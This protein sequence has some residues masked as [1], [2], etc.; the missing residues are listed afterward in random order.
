MQKDGCCADRNQAQHDQGIL[1][2]LDVV[3]GIANLKGTQ[4]AQ[5]G[6][7]AEKAA[8]GGRGRRGFAVSIGHP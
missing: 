2:K 1:G 3:C 7:V 5:K 6:C 8:G 4:D